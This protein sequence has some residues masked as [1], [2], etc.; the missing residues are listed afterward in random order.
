ME[1]ESNRSREISGKET[2]QKY[3]EQ[4]HKNQTE[5]DKEKR[6]KFEGCIRKSIIGIKW[7]RRK[8]RNPT[9]IYPLCK[10][11]FSIPLPDLFLHHC[12]SSYCIKYHIHYA[13]NLQALTNQNHI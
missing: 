10:S 6:E 4:H 11:A 2:Q 5:K 3:I 8:K 7:K 9:F 12:F 1:I 13:V